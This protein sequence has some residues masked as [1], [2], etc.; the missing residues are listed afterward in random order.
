MV[1]SVLL[2]MRKVPP[3]SVSLGNEIFV[4]AV[5]LSKEREL[6]TRVTFGAEIEGIKESKKPRLEETF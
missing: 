2:A 3:I 4:R 1:R 5:Q 6:P